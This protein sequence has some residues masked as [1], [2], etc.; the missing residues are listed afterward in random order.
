MPAPPSVHSDGVLF[1][2]Y[3]NGHIAKV[4]P[5]VRAL[6]AHGVHCWV[7]AMTLGFMQARR[8]GLQPLCYSNFMHLVDADEALTHGRRLWPE[9]QHPD[10][11]EFESC[12]Y[13]GVNY[14]DW[15]EAYGEQKAAELYAK[16]G[17]RSFMP[18]RFMGRVIESLNPAVV[19]STSSPRSEQAAIE[20][21]MARKVPSLTM[22]DVFANPHD[23]YL[24]YA[25]YADRITAPSQYAAH[26]LHE[27]GIEPARI[28]VTGCP[29]YD[30]LH[31][32]IGP[33]EG[34]AFR[35]TLGWNGL[36]IVL[37][38]GSLE[39]PSPPSS[40]EHAG[41]GLCVLVEQALR[42]WVRSR[43]EVALVVRYHPTQYHLFPNRGPQDRVY[44]SNSA[45]DRLG[46]QLHAADTVLVQT[47]TVGFEAALLGKRVLNLAFSPT[48]IHTE[49]DFS[50]LGLAE[51]VPSLDALTT[52]LDRPRQSTADIGS[53]PPEGEATPRVVAEILSLMG[54]WR[55]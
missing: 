11:D 15:V 48:V 29:A 44:V 41:P 10:V 5:V 37:W 4:A 38:C 12:C 1:V 30:Y 55:G 50:K 39:L 26:Q 47:S 14:L 19:V 16:G 24:H 35:Q 7:L 31:D 53:R 52:V 22:L 18:L 40:P 32:A 34:L 42:E 43:P 46:P 2:T 9:N 6:E 51:A 13:L 36:Q 8:L 27:A 23:T 17:R 25:V 45:Q 49:Y 54:G 21:A 33:A 28:R 3:G 20:A